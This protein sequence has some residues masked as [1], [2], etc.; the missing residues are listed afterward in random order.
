MRTTSVR[1]KIS[2]AVCRESLLLA[3]FSLIIRYRSKRMF[4][5]DNEITRD[6]IDTKLIITIYHI[7]I[8]MHIF[9]HLFQYFYLYIYIQPNT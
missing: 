6:Q 5:I 9:L 1:C 4:F 7:Y 3:L 2:Q 8:H